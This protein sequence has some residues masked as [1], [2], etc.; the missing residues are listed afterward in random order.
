[1]GNI[2]HYGRIGYGQQGFGYARNSGGNGQIINGLKINWVLQKKEYFIKLAHNNG[3]EIHFVWGS[4]YPQLPGN[5]VP[6]K[7]Y[8]Y[9]H[10]C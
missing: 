5:R 1:L 6:D 7:I 8:Y 10:F 2:P 9:G 3:R 4:I